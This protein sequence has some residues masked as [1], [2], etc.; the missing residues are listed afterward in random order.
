M[1]DFTGF[2]SDIQHSFAPHG[3]GRPLAM[4]LLVPD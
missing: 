4:G 2:F 3:Q 1:R